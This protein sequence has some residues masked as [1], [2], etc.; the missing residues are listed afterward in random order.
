MVILILL[1]STV[2]IFA[3]KVSD[4]R[5]LGAF[6]AEYFIGGGR[7]GGWSW[8][9]EE[10]TTAF[11]EIEITGEPTNLTLYSYEGIA[12]FFV[13]PHVVSLTAIPISKDEI[14]L[15]VH[16]GK[17]WELDFEHV[18]IQD[19]I[20]S[21]NRSYGG[22]ERVTIDGQIAPN[23][24]ISVEPIML[25]PD[26]MGLAVKGTSS[27]TGRSGA[28]DILQYKD[29]GYKHVF[30]LP[31]YAE[32]V[33]KGPSVRITDLNWASWNEYPVETSTLDMASLLHTWQ[34]KS[35][36]SW[37]SSTESFIMVNQTPSDFAVINSFLKHIANGEMEQAYEFLT[38]E[39]KGFID[40]SSTIDRISAFLEEELVFMPFYQDNYPYSPRK[41]DRFI[42]I[43]AIHPRLMLYR[44]SLKR[45]MIFEI[46]E[47]E[48]PEIVYIQ[49]I[50]F[51]PSELLSN[52]EYH[53][54]PTMDFDKLG[55]QWYAD[56]NGWEETYSK[57]KNT[58]RIKPPGEWIEI[59]A[60][61]RSPAI[62]WTE[63]HYAAEL[64]FESTEDAIE[65]YENTVNTSVV[66]ITIEVV[67]MARGALE[68]ESLRF[69]LSTESGQ[70]WEG[71][72]LAEPLME[73]SLFGAKVYMRAFH[74]EFDTTEIPLDW[75]A[76][77][78]STLHVIRQDKLERADV[79]WDF[80]P[81][82]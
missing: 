33:D 7:V 71:T 47:D 10:I 66:P 34:S 58:V 1:T 23:E 63:S 15:F 61:L 44:S 24:S 40:F 60:T 29:G 38:E 36:F 13:D 79:V 48:H 30:R 65:N 32:I 70:R 39:L 68:E 26:T 16:L 35:E 77:S 76:T 74:V 78:T 67:S 21:W 17:T 31:S 37:D 52:K 55:F 46:S 64:R 57:V 9:V 2:H 45:V 8:I 5:R 11:P 19:I 41:S 4:G 73:A 53:I 3:S 80:G 6:L 82:P 72:F 75:S 56:L 69:V 22:F 62:I 43:G 12:E 49:E 59:N 28:L 81:L 27:I 18:P 50:T 20:L 51:V 14:H 42:V 25:D 54:R